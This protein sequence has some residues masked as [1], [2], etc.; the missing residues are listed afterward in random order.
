MSV[1]QAPIATREHLPRPMV[2]YF[3]SCFNDALECFLSSPSERSLTPLMMLP[4]ALTHSARAGVA[5]RHRQ[6]A[7]FRNRLDR[8]NLRG[9][10]LEL[11]SIA[12][13]RVSHRGPIVRS[14]GN[15]KARVIQLCRE[16][17]YSKAVKALIAEQLLEPTDEV[18]QQL[19]QLHPSRYE[20]WPRVPSMSPDELPFT[21]E[22][23][24]MAVSDAIKSFPA[25]SA[26]GPSGLKPS[27]L[28]DML[29]SPVVA[30]RE[31]FVGLL[32]RL[33]KAAVTG[34]LPLDVAPSLMAGNLLPFAK[35]AGGVRPIAVGETL[36]RLISKV[37]VQLC[38]AKFH[39]TFHP[40]QVGVAV[41]AATE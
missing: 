15:V 17:A 7:Q 28:R 20:E 16:G 37:L 41:P 12:S 26:A 18:T 35:P 2:S 32:S 40:D 38:K 14:D 36:R 13:S 34:S 29:N 10:P 30:V 39:F 4:K 19:R 8:W 23:I 31:R 24:R 5:H 25:M 22:Q 9:G 27:H 11:W 1:L 21:D 3:T 33:V 6:A